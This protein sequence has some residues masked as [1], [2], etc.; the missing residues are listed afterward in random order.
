MA[1]ITEIFNLNKTQYELDFVDIDVNHDT[2]LFIDP[3]WI[4][5]QDCDF[6]I[7]CDLLIKSFFTKLVDLIKRNKMRE[8]V[9]LCSYLS[10][11]S[12]ICLGY[13]KDRGTNG[14]GIGP[15]TANKFCFALK[16]SPAFQGD[17]LVNIEDTKIFLKDIDVDRVSDMVANIIR[18]VLIEYTIQQCNNYNIPLVKERT[19]YFWD[20]NSLSWERENNIEQLIIGNKRILLVP[21]KIVSSSNKYTWDNFLQHYILN[22]LQEYNINDKTSLVMQRKD[23]TEYVTKKS[24]RE[25]YE[26]NGEILDKSFC[27]QFAL[28]H[29]EVYELFKNEIIKK[30]VESAIK[31]EE[32]EADRAQYFKDKLSEI[33]PGKEDENLYQDIILDIFVFIFGTKVSCPSKEVKINDGRKRIDIAFLNSA[34]S[35]ILY[36]IHDKYHIPFNMVI[37]ECK[38]YS[39]DVGNPEIDQ[40]A[41]RF[42]PKRGKCG[43][44]VFRDIKKYDL[45]M[46]RCKDTYAEDRGLIIPIMDNDLISVFDSIIDGKN[47]FEEIIKA[48][49]F[50]IIKN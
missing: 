27:E 44:L 22:A 40:L 24:I 34:S 43:F 45:F 17:L 4:S 38:N 14:S 37:M 12:D 2:E 13:S 41:G 15:L 42:S 36:D 5:K 23:G 19:N 10:E 16:Q 46:K 35:G 47:N 26:K 30:Y 8:A 31:V 1:K 9:I 33:K 32:S 20:G 3:Y 11:S 25:E 7:K 39:N 49:I 28:N 48:K 29:P 18:K 50:E 6:T 21:K